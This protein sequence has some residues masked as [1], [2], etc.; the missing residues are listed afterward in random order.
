M[1]FAVLVSRVV[2]PLQWWTKPRTAAEIERRFPKL[3]Q[4][5]RTVVQYAGL[6]EERVHLEGVTPSLFDAL[7]A[8]TEIQAEPLDLDAIIPGKRLLATSA[9]AALPTL[10]LVIAVASGVE[11]R[12][13]MSRA[14]LLDRPYTT[15]SVRP[16]SLT[17]DQ[18][19]TVPIAA[20]LEGRPQRDVI[21]QT[22]PDGKPGTP[23]TSA[24]LRGG[25]GPK[26]DGKL[27]KVQR[28]IAY[29]VSA[30]ST[31]SPTYVV[32][33][34][35]PLAVR[36]FEVAMN[37]PAYT[38]M[39]PNTL[40]GGDIRAL[41]GTLATFRIAFDSPP[42]EASLVLDDPSAH[43]KGKDEHPPQVIRLHDGGSALTAELTLTKGW[44]YRIEARTTDGRVLPRNRYRIDVRDDHPR[45][46]SSTNPTK[47][48]R[49]TPWPKCGTGSTR[50]TTSG[51]PVPASSSGSTTARSRPWSP[52]TSRR[53]RRG[54]ADHRDGDR[55]DAP[56][57]EA[58]RIDHG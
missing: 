6:S 8:E 3:G 24:P 25:P 21:L 50:A 58:R 2:M 42:V 38:G 34:R 7:E 33:V 16:G 30:G 23:W 10:A 37:P 32:R 53:P 49:S 36:L 56:P 22:R 35:S 14:L 13:A 29:R 45:A 26:R 51:S 12:I 28:A 55:G 41:A 15:L 46:S 5:V 27:E 39:K 47:R 4:R 44:I 54:Q 19:Q 48:L 18:G 17:V 40:K 11:W 9:L 20:E 43:A 31:S 1:S 57:G 52:A